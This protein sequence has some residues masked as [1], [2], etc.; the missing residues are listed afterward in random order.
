MT[1]II[2]Q[3]TIGDLPQVHA[4]IGLLARHHGDV[5]TIS[6]ETLRRQIFDDA[7]GHLAV[8]GEEEGLVG[9]ALLLPRPNLVTGGMRHD[10][11]H[12]FVVEWRR[13]AGIGRAL[14][15]ALRQV[16]LAAGAEYLT[17]STHPANVAAQNAYARM[18]LRELP[19]A[20]RFKIELV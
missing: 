6:L 17:I 13:K 16:S 5:P 11:N 10:I 7:V 14:I 8:A 12:L 4:M 18:G 9:Y 3:A 2:R 15:A 20:P 19:A 1:L